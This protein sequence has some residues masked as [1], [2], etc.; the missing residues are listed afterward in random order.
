MS[1]KPKRSSN[2]AIILNKILKAA[3]DQQLE[4]LAYLINRSFVEGIV[5]HCLKLAR[6]ILLFKG[7]SR[8][9]QNN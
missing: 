5:P 1:L 4:A 6:V 8:E 7:G 9:D 2:F 3:V